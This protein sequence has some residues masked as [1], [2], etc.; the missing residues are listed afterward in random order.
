M[1]LIRFECRGLQFGLPLSYVYRVLPSA[2]PTPLPGAP[3]VVLG[4]LNFGRQLITVINFYQRI[5]LPFTAI[6]LSQQ[7]LV[8]N[9]RDHALGLLV[10]TVQGVTE[11]DIDDIASVPPQVRGA[12]CFDGVVRLDDGVCVICDPEKFLFGDEKLLLQDALEKIGH[13][14]D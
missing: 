3:S 9:S 6:G 4:V 8:L 14:P 5:G 7:L 11:H 2:Q 13:E 10:D 1:M 12:E